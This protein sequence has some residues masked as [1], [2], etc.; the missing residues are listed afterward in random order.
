MKLFK[1]FAALALAGVMTLGLLTGCGSTR[2]TYGDYV[3]DY[4][5]Q[6]V[7]SMR[8]WA[9]Q[10][11][12]IELN[13]KTLKNDACLRKELKQMLNQIDEYGIIN[14]SDAFQYSANLNGE[15]GDLTFK[16]VLTTSM[17]DDNVPYSL[18]DLKKRDAELD[19]E[20]LFAVDFS[21][22]NSEGQYELYYLLRLFKNLTPY[23]DS[24][25]IEYRIVGD[26]VMYVAIGFTAEGEVGL[27]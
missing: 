24:F 18:A 8:Y 17:R 4:T 27:T 23:M 6:Q 13:P 5:M 16:T 9:A 15:G 25:A 2:T 7:N 10:D 20:T 11:K 3:V 19:D 1:R 14:G 26:G 21:S 22:I 12:E